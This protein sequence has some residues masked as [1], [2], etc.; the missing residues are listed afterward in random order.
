M[1]EVL[2]PH[3]V[4]A[5]EAILAALLL[6]DN[7][8]HR[9]AGI[10]DRGDFFREQNRWAYEAALA[11]SGR[12]EPITV[13]TLAHELERA[14]RLDAAGGEQ[15]L[16]GLAGKYYTAVGVEAHGRIVARDAQ[17]RRLIQVSGRIAHLAY[18]GGHD[19]AAVLAEAEA[20]LGAVAANTSSS[21]Y[22]TAADVVARLTDPDY[23]AREV[24]RTGLRPL[25]RLIGGFGLGD[26]IC[27]G[28]H[29]S[30][31]KTALMAQIALNMVSAGT[32]VGYLAI[33]GND[34]KIVERMAAMLSGYTR[35]RAERSGALPQYLGALEVIGELPLYSVR[36]ES[37]P[38]S[39]SAIASWVTSLARSE[40]VQVF[41]IDHIDD[42]EVEREHGD[43]M[44]TAYHTGLR[45][46]QNTAARENV[47]IVFLSQV[48][49]R[50][51]GDEDQIP[52]M[53]M[54]RDSGAKEELSQ[55][56]LMLW[57]DY[58]E[59]AQA[60]AT[61]HAGGEPARWLWI[62][63]EKHTEGSVGPVL[64][65]SPE[66]PAIGDRLPPFLLNLRSMTVEATRAGQRSEPALQRGLGLS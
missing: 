43:N 1:T 47:A 36:R 4:G 29:T 45:R 18:Q 10:V 49:R 57:L 59:E 34:D 7:A 22:E 46:L 41:I 51:G 27:V 25:D 2:P 23:R 48:N 21:R 37:T 11:V 15:F 30:H 64:G 13:A 50:T 28:A 61:S 42:V 33:E 24:I 5:E 65:P 17:Y 40:G 54:L 55:L 35:D 60:S 52:S 6:D 66:P 63:V 20:L 14:G 58:R 38:R 32:R 3:D 26:L 44:A 62:N 12:G 19:A 31:G 56:V 9:V 53:R 16:V 8:V 39:F